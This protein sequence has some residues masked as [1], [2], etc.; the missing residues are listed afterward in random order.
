[1]MKRLWM[2]A[3]LWTGVAQAQNVSLKVQNAD[4]VSVLRAIARAGGVNLV[5]SPSVKGT[6]TLE[7][8]DVP[9]KRAFETVLQVSG[10]AS[11]EN[12]DV[13]TVMT[14]A[15]L[16]Q[17]VGVAG[18]TTRLFPVKFTNAQKIAEVL[19]KFL[20]K[21]G[22]M[23]VDVYSNT[24]IVTD[25]PATLDKIQAILD[26]LDRPTPQ[27][28][29]QAKIVQVDRSAVQDLGINWNTG[30]LG[31]SAGG[32]K[33]GVQAEQTV[34]NA[35]SFT[36]GRVFNTFDLFAKI[37]AL[38]TQNKAQVLSEPSILVADNVEAEIKSGKKIPI[39]TQDQAGN[40]IVRF[41]DIVLRLKVT[42]HVS[43][44]GQITLDLNPELSELSEQV[45]A[46]GYPIIITHEASTRLTLRNGETVVL[47]G[48][49]KEANSEATAGI[50]FLSRIPVLGWLLG[51][52]Q[53][54]SKS[55]GEI[56]IFVTPEIVEDVAAAGGEETGMTE[57]P[58]GEEGMTEET[59]SGS[60]EGM[61]EAPESGTETPTEVDVPVEAT[62]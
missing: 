34:E 44:D 1:M 42:P 15:E 51:G 55:K 61:T 30:T 2:I 33:W 20:T 17:Y 56:L 46:G 54:F 62:E 59:P 48:V 16:D 25:V 5:I 29:I 43:P 41:Y 18:L 3:L 28:R 37:Q 4:V 47:G 40:R 39:V 7:L 14:P 53:K 50:P 22:E 49:I 52:G 60:V 58:S 6:V 9:W 38:E 31:R 57:A 36:Y 8:Q 45:G 11:M 27:V 10:L 12:E 23:D 19:R 13:I 24:L 35:P 26:S 21:R 32:A